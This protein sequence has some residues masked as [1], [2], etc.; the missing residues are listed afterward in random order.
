MF[1]ETTLIPPPCPKRPNFGACDRKYT[2]SISPTTSVGVSAAM[3]FPH[4]DQAKHLCRP[5]GPVRL[6][7]AV[8]LRRALLRAWRRPDRFSEGDVERELRAYGSAGDVR[9]L[10]TAD[11]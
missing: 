8:S 11:R 6:R 9:G 4:F 3:S 7:H 10:V 5:P 2:T 1:D